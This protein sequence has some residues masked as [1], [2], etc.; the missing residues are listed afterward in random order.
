MILT[1]LHMQNYKK[2]QDFTLEFVEGLTGIIGRNGSGK[3]TIFDAITFALYGDVRGEKETIRNAKAGEKDTVSVE[4]LFEIEGLNYKVLRE[5]RGKSLTAKAYLYD[6]DDALIAES[7]K[8]VT[9]EIIRLIGM[10]REAFMHTV[11]ASQKEL[12]ALSGLKSEE[13]KKIIRKLLGLEKIDKIEQEIKSKLTDLNRDIKSFSEILL[14]EAEVKALQE[15]KEAKAKE[16]ETLQKEVEKVKK[17]F[18]TKSKEVDGLDKALKALQ[19][20]KEAFVKLGSDLEL[21]QTNLNNLKK[22][23]LEKEEK[24]GVLQVKAAQ[25]EKEKP[26][27]EEYKTLEVQI[28]NFQKQKELFLKKEG[29]EREQVALRKQYEDDKQEI[30]DLKKKLEAK[31]QLL[32]EQE[33]QKT[34]FQ[35][36][37]NK[38]KE[39][40]AKESRLGQEIA[41]YNGL[42]ENTNKQIAKIETL[43]KDSDCPTCTRP[44]LD[45][46]DNVIA[47]LKS[48][49]TQLHHDEI[50][51]RTAELK[52]VLETKTK[53][54]EAKSKIEQLLQKLSG[55]LR[56]MESDEKT[57]AQKVEEFKSITATGL[58]N[59]EELEA[60]KDVKYDEKAHSEALAKK[61]K[62]E[63]QYNE[64]LGL[65]TLIAQIPALENE[66]KSIDQTIAQ[67]QESIK[68]QEK[69]IAEHSYDA[70][71]HEKQE[72]LYVEVRKVKDALSEALSKKRVE[73]TQIMGEITTLKSKLDRNE[74][75]KKQ[76]Q[77]KLND[78][79]DYEK[80]KAFMGEFKNKIN[81]QIAPRISQLASE[82]YG[83][84]T[85]GKYQHIEVSNEF[86]F[87]IYD[88]GVR[89]PIERFSGGEVDLANLVLRIAISKTLSELSGSGG[90]GFLAFDEVFGSQ[91]E[92]RRFEI[93]EAFHTIKEQYRQIFLISHESEIKEMFERMVEL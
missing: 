36:S 15:Q 25:Y 24:L 50:A 30:Q 38:L 18:E 79:N 17:E 16:A 3:S 65:A 68:K 70:K 60:L 19:T 74:E 4:L 71:E 85:R 2:Y 48:T 41:K 27:V 6:G 45:E 78:K 56:V 52:T 64:L 23:K 35:T 80:L 88:D 12:T 47:S 26:L 53:E 34:L 84:I 51:K 93:M 91:D 31:P 57:L 82:M 44:L 86:D 58:K 39:I 1:S 21:L 42:I 62:L 69:A 11:F 54:H 67:S 89:Y 76:L 28:T 29:L 9:G 55:D 32:K 81:S 40:E 10:N 92:E 33:A 72:T 37:A 73:H 20:L 46:Y 63:P 59:K 5:M 14:S 43:G 77:T 7:A 8:G 22:N 49:I 13:R 61:E 75:Q 90:V 83:S 87:F 66:L